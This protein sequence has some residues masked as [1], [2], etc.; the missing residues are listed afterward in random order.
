MKDRGFALIGILIV[1]IVLLILFAV[2][3]APSLYKQ[4]ITTR[5]REA[6]SRL[7]AIKKAMVG[8]PD[9]TSTEKERTDFGFLGDW[10]SLPDSLLD[11]IYP[12]TPVWQFDKGRRL[13]AGWKGPYIDIHPDDLVYSPWGDEYVYNTVDYVNEEGS[14]VDAVLISYGEDRVASDDD[15]K[16][17]IL[18]SETTASRL[19]GYVIT[20]YEKHPAEDVQVAISYPMNGSITE[21]SVIT[22][23]HGYYEFNDI[24]FGM[25]VISFGS[26]GAGGVSYIE[27]SAITQ[28]EDLEFWVQSGV[29][30]DVEITW[31]RA[32]YSVDTYY[33][34]VKFDRSK[35]WEWDGVTRAGSGDTTYF[36]S[37]KVLEGGG[38]SIRFAVTSS[39]TNVSDMV[40]PVSANDPVPVEYLNFEDDSGK[41]Y[42]MAGEQITVTFSNG[43]VITFIPAAQ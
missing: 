42:D 28:R 20:E 27:G 31:M 2:A 35:V 30:A 13:G 7:E 16:V 6:S 25:R 32:D 11:L 22:N 15:Q 33:E 3:V 38:N 29:T 24:P 36:D 9:L 41:R 34:I 17:E 14:L 1:P 12:K 18:K 37:P 19:R 43:S 10:G 39:Q 40:S 21:S 4:L 8:N 23:E 5:E 26:S